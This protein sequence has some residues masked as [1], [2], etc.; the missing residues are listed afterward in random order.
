[1][2]LACPS[3]NT[4][5]HRSSGWRLND[6]APIATFKRTQQLF[7]AELAARLLVLIRMLQ[8][9]GK[10]FMPL[11]WLLFV[12]S[13]AGSACIASVHNQ[14][15]QPW[16]YITTNRIHNLLDMV[17]ELSPLKRVPAVVVDELQALS[18][19]NVVTDGDCTTPLMKALADAALLIN[20]PFV[21]SGTRMDI[22]AVDTMC[23]MSIAK[24]EPRQEQIVL[25]DFQYLTR[26]DVHQYLSN[27]LDL[28]GVSTEVIAQLSYS[29]Q[30]RARL[31][32]QFFSE[33]LLPG[34]EALKNREKLTDATL[35]ST[36]ET[37]MQ[38]RVI[39]AFQCEIAH[40]LNMTGQKT[41]V[42]CGVC[43]C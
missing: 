19:R 2:I 21:W 13:D 11:Q 4:P 5:A 26:A 8:L 23:C 43:A 36:L 12:Q 35:L 37:F 38:V 18:G 9:K 6:S 39:E 30:G 15:C 24:C 31:I 7:Y 25:G 33:L 17:A 10:D 1:M 27:I 16:Q 20:C 29:L 40:L 32:T 41:S 3:S 22:Q 14:L 34:G 28:T 42:I